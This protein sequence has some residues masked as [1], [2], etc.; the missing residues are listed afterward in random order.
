MV[1]L[2]LNMYCM[3]G[4]LID[5]GRLFL[6]AEYSELRKRGID[7]SIEQEDCIVSLKFDSYDYLH[8]NHAH[9]AAILSYLIKGY[10]HLDQSELPMIVWEFL[11][12]ET[13]KEKVF[14]YTIFKHVADMS[15]AKVTYDESMKDISAIYLREFIHLGFSFCLM[16][17]DED[18]VSIDMA[19]VNSTEPVDIAEWTREFYPVM[20]AVLTDLVE[21]H[22]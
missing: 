5:R 11:K 20:T 7:V 15:R 3:P 18:V 17:M 2:R 16:R 14:I 9:T 13:D 4:S 21:L 1:A 10:I 22:K 8:E 6:S 19:V 12:I